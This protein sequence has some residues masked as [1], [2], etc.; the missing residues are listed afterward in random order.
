MTLALIGTKLGMTHVFTDDGSMV[1]VTVIAC[2]PCPILQV[3]TAQ[4][5]GYA[6]LQL[7]Y[8]QARETAVKRAQ[9][10]HDE[11]RRAREENRKP[12]IQAPKQVLVT[13]AELGHARR[14]G[15]PVP[16]IIREARVDDTSPYSVGQVLTCDLFSPGELVDVIGTSKGRGFAGPMKRHHSSRGPETHGSN[17]H[18]RPGS[19]GASADP[20]RVRKGKKMAG[21][22][23]NERTT[24][25]NLQVVQTDPQKNILL[26]RGAVP[27][28]NGAIV[29]V[30]KSI[31]AATRGVRKDQ[32][33]KAA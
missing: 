27:G 22:M 26:L 3:K 33:R 13:Q 21:R 15:V 30:R 18:R 12:R 29:M 11:R 1:P 14:A 28:F 23:G 6:A 5:D 7:G 9:H 8:G 10:A 25:L 32:K 2:G 17:Y 24:V 20:S 19:G 16:Q 31:H 4:T